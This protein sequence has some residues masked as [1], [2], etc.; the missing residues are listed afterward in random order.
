MKKVLLYV[1]CSVLLV[2]LGLGGG[3]LLFGRVA[4]QSKPE[5]AAPA[6]VAVRIS[7]GE[8]EWSLGNGWNSAGTLG[9][10]AAGDPYAPGLQ[11]SE[12]PQPDAEAAPIFSALKVPVYVQ[13]PAASGGGGGGGGGGAPSGGGGGAPAGGGGATSGDGENIGWSGDVLD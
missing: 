10:L 4:P 6:S 11:W 2:G 3:Y 13:T 12:Y 8:V 5:A 7:D 9:E 1:L